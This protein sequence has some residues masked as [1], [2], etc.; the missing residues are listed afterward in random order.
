MIIIF[1]AGCRKWWLDHRRSQFS[2][3][4]PQGGG[5]RRRWPL[6][7]CLSVCVCLCL[8]VCPAPDPKSRMERHSKLKIGRK[9][10]QDMDDPWPD[11]EVERSQVKV[12]RALKPWPKISHIFGTWRTTPVKLGTLMDYDD[13]ITEVC[14]DLHS[15]SSGWLFKSP[16]VGAGAYYGCPTTDHPACLVSVL[17]LSVFRVVHWGYFD[18]IAL[19]ILCSVSWLFWLDCH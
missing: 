11:L 12:T 13:R 8:S 1:P 5:I 10:A 14:G 15:G 6:S 3:A 19:F 4:C 7:V 17:H 16:I 2:L 18:C 9:E